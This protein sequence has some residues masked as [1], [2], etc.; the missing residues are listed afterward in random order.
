MTLAD[1]GQKQ[2][3][4]HV[5]AHVICERTTSGVQ[6]GCSGRRLTEPDGLHQR[7]DDQRRR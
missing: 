2:E 3:C 1:A 4:I 5:I 7:T 6:K